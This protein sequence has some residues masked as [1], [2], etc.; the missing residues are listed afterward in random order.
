MEPRTQQSK[1]AAKYESLSELLPGQAF[2]FMNHGF[3][4]LEGTD[5]ISWLNESDRKYVYN[6]Q[7]L[8]QALAGTEPR[9]KD[10]LEVGCGRG[11]NCAI[12]SRYF[13]PRRVVGVD[14]SSAG[15]NLC[16]R[17]NSESMVTFIAGSAMSLPFDAGSFDVVLN[18]ESSHCYPNRQDFY[19]EAYRVLR[20]GGRLCYADCLPPVRLDVITRALAHTG[21]I[22]RETRDITQNVAE[23]IKRRDQIHRELLLGAA[24]SDE[25]RK[26]AVSIANSVR[27]RTFNNYR[28]RRAVYFIWY[29]Q[30]PN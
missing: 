11:G 18:I 17:V 5:C 30:R 4:N 29:A 28:S 13:S 19:E 22:L 25:G 1:Q 10:I 24:S 23:S 12:L 3:A 2:I 6:V 26:S 7:L 16:T 15:I 20:P 9:N 8:I 14:V 21:F 27:H